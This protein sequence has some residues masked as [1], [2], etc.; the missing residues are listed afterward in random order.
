MV[1]RQS[2]FKYKT[3]KGPLHKWPVML[4][5][6]LLLPLSIF[7]LA[8]P[9]F[10]LCIGIITAVIFAFLCRFTLREQLTDLKPAVIYAVIMY[11]LSVFSNFYNYLKDIQF[12]FPDSFFS[13]HCS[14][15]SVNCSLFSVLCPHPDYLRITLRLTLIIQLSALLFRTTSSIEIRECLCNIELFIKRSF[16][17]LPFFKKQISLRAGFA[18][19][20]SVFLMFIPEIFTIWSNIDLAWKARGGKNGFKKMTMLVFVLISISFEKAAI[21]A[22]ALEARGK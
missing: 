19:N 22:K 21:K 16:A 15:F 3:I 7:C 12:I 9:S 18:E 10:W 4:K 2:I 13:V 17:K 1:S 6:F 11:A 5:L 14:L 20:I 8:L